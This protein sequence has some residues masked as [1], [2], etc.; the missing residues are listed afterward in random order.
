MQ[1]VHE[2]QHRTLL[3][4]F[5]TYKHDVALSDAATAH[6]VLERNSVPRT[7]E[8]HIV[9]EHITWCKCLM[10]CRRLLVPDLQTVLVSKFANK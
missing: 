2:E 6:P 8:T 3:S 4:R 5:V 1:T 7:I 10:I 9:Q